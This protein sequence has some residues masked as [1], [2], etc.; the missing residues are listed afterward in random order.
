MKQHLKEK[1]WKEHLAPE[2]EKDYFKTL[3]KFVKNEYAF[4]TVYPKKKW[5]F[6]A[7]NKCPF[8]KVD[9]VIIGQDPYPTEGLA[10]GL[11]FSVPDKIKKFP[12]SLVNIFKEIERD[13]AIPYPT[14]GNL[15]HWAKQGVLLLNTILT[16]AQE[17]NKN[18]HKDKGWELF[19]D[20]VIR[21][22]S[23]KRD[24]LVF[25]LWGNSAKEKK[26][27]INTARQHLV[28]ESYHP[29]P[30]SAHRGFFGN[31]HFSQI[32]NFL[33]SADEEPIRW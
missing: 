33:L 25:L 8:D 31:N 21:L 15:T 9:V 18:S 5:I 24:H 6:R 1:G 28:L 30:L 26:K 32:N 11:A 22:L 2:F 20:A 17:G 14:S 4:Y 16:F 29:S 19:T 27:H 13:L 12:P 3:K 10:H 23:D 7:F